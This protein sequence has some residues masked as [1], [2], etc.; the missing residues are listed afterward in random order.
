MAHTARMFLFTD[1][2]LRHLSR[3]VMQQLYA[4]APV[5]PEYAGTRQR[6][7]EVYIEFE[8]KKPK[9]IIDMRGHTLKFDD[10]GGLVRNDPQRASLRWTLSDQ[11][12]KLVYAAIWGK[13]VIP[14]A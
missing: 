14:L 1:A 3:R 5:L 4:G 13:N 7:A 2:G 12:R 8:D 9:Q 11:D 6:V 10:R